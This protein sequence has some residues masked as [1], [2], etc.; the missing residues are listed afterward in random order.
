MNEGSDDDEKE[1]SQL[2]G[3]IGV[4]FIFTILKA[5]P[6]LIYFALSIENIGLQS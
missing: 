2:G 3:W 4:V 5:S 6:T 1:K